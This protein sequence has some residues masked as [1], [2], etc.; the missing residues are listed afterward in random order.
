[1]PS[2]GTGHCSRRR[3]SWQPL[4]TIGSLPTY[5]YRRGHALLMRPVREQGQAPPNHERVDRVMRAHG[6][7]LQ[8]RAVGAE[9]CRHDGRMAVKHS[10][11]R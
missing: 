11:L 10:N 2:A 1:M 9:A 6:H 5:G 3:I 7:T 4:T 8:R